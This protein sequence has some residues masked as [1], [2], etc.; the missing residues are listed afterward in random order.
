MEPLVIKKVMPCS[1]RQLFDAWAKP[2]VMARWFFASQTPV[3]DST[4]RNSFT[5]GGSY[6]LTM[7]LQT[8]DYTMSGEYVEI[9][10]YTRITFTWSSHI[11]EGS[12]V[13]LDFRE[14]SPNRTEMTLTQTRFPS[15]EVRA[16]HDQG[17]NG[18]LSSLERFLEREYAV[19]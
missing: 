15:D 17:W 9:N 14:L 7:H 6:S 8:G 16:S 18:C 2:S 19:G 11:I 5:V 4:V 13:Q 1:K 12:L 3:K 10:R